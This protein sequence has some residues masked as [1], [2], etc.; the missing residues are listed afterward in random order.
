MRIYPLNTPKLSELMKG[1]SKF[2]FPDKKISKEKLMMHI[3]NVQNT[4]VKQK[5]GEGRAFDTT[6]KNKYT[7]V[8]QESVD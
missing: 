8:Y 6:S 4:K 7:V 5:F 3:K 2:K 1:I